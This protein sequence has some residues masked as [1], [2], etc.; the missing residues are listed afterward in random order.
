MKKFAIDS[1]VVLLCLGVGSVVGYMV[2][3]VQMDDFRHEAIERGFWRKGRWV[4]PEDIDW[5]NL[6]D[7][8]RALPDV[9]K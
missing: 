2:G 4:Q 1:F 7:R 9:A 3:W 5:Y 6:R 8:Q